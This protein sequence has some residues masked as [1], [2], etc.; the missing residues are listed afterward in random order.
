MFLTLDQNRLPAGPGG[1]ALW[2]L[3]EMC[4]GGDVLILQFA[5]TR[6]GLAR[7]L[8]LDFS[9]AAARTLVQLE[10]DGQIVRGAAVLRARLH[11]DS[12]QWKL[13]KVSEIHLGATEALDGEHPLVSFARFTTAAGEQISLPVGVADKYSR[14]R[15]IYPSNPARSPGIGRRKPA[16]NA[17]TTS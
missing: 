4:D 8:M 11:Q 5:E 15:R 17:A 6:R 7:V 10:S 1:I 9:S 14:G 13:E 12:A 2:P 3:A 16:A